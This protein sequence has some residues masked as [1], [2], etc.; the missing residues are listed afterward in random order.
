MIAR[1]A[2]IPVNAKAAVRPHETAIT[3]KEKASE[4]QTNRVIN[5][6]RF[7]RLLTLAIFDKYLEESGVILLLITNVVIFVA[8]F[9][10]QV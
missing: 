6:P 2:H 10:M 8:F 1:A 9:F 5:T 3:K 7:L 4:Y